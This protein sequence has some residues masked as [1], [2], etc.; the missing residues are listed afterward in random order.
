[1]KGAEPTSV[2]LDWARELANQLVGRIKNRLLPFGVRLQIGLLGLVDPKLFQHQL[3][4]A[5]GM[6][7]YAARTLRGLVLVTVQGLPDDAALSYV[8]GATNAG[9]T[10]GA[11]LW[12]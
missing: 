12:L 10:E 3:R 9:A 2:R 5:N 8:G 4:E 11:M 6:R 1:M 7:V